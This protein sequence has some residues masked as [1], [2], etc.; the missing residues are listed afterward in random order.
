M[1]DATCTSSLLVAT[2]GSPSWQARGIATCS[3]KCWNKVR[4]RYQWVV[5]GYVVMPEHVRLLVNEPPHR[6]LSTAIQALKLGF[7]R[8][9][10]AELRRQHPSELIECGKAHLAGAIL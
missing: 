5:L 1:A 9:L 6:P 3:S 4:Q 7:A 2:A 8:R 10:L